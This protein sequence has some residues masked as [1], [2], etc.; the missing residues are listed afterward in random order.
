[1]EYPTSNHFPV[2]NYGILSRSP[3]KSRDRQKRSH[4]YPSLLFSDVGLDYSDISGMDEKEVSQV[5]TSPRLP[6]AGA[7]MNAVRNL[8]VYG[9]HIQPH[10]YTH[11]IARKLKEEMVCLDTIKFLIFKFNFQLLCGK[12]RKNHVLPPN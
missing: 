2:C 9:C 6:K 3:T 7:S 1:M 11:C 5:P 8:G 12:K 4:G 10:S